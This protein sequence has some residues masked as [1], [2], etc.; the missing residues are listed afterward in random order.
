MLLSVNTLGKNTVPVTDT[1]GIYLN[2]TNL[3]YGTGTI[4][5]EILLF[6]SK[7]YAIPIYLECVYKVFLEYQ[8][9]FRPDKYDF[10]KTSVKYVG[11]DIT[12]VS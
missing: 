1:D 7:L 10:L 2:N 11:H 8:V 12:E 5:D 9:S 6:C 3:V 4:I